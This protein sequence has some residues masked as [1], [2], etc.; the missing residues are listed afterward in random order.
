MKTLTI[1][2]LATI[3]LSPLAGHDSFAGPADGFQQ[4]QPVCGWDSLR[5]R[6][7]YPDLGVRAGLDERVT[8]RITIDAHGNIDTIQ[9]SEFNKVFLET[10]KNAIFST[11]WFP[12]FRDG[13]PIKSTLSIPIIF[14]IH[15]PWVT[16]PLV[17]THEPV[18]LTFV[19]TAPKP[20]L[21]DTTVEDLPIDRPADFG[22]VLK[23]GT[24]ASRFEFDSLNT[25]A[26]TLTIHDCLL[27]TTISL[28]L[29]Q[30]QMDSVYRMTT[31]IHLFRYPAQLT[32]M[33][34]IYLPRS[35]CE[36]TIHAAGRSK[37]ISY[38]FTADTVDPAANTLNLFLSKIHRM[39]STNPAYRQL[40]ERHCVY[41]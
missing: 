9:F 22:F 14:Q 6:I 1:L 25:L 11:T 23:S 3:V 41:E 13:N 17:I 33:G 19:R 26:N 21:L 28:S 29:T 32:S 18:A 37:T 15:S 16:N 4:A 10:I 20:I 40:P 35:E 39:I 5:N 34:M 27:D 31:T 36:L 12:A 2:I 30:Q 24:Y 7:V 38:D 8:V